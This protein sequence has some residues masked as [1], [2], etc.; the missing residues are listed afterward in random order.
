VAKDQVVYDCE[1]YSN[2]FMLAFKHVATGKTKVFEIYHDPDTGETLDT[3]DCDEVKKVF[4]T[5]EVV[6]FN[7]IKFDDPLIAMALAGRTTAEIKR[8]ADMII[9]EG[10][11]V[12]D[13]EKA[14]NFKTLKPKRE[15]DLIEVKVGDCSLKTLGGRMHSKRMQDLP[16]DPEE[17]ITR[18]QLDELRSYC[19]NDLDT[20]IDLLKALDGPLK[21]RRDMIQTYPEASQYRS[22]M[23]LSEGQIAEA[24][25][26]FEAEKNLG[27][28]ISK[29]KLTSNFSFGY[30]PASWL[31][32][33]TPLLQ[34]V[35]DVVKNATF[36]VDDK[37][38]IVI[39]KEILDLNIKIGDMTYTLAVGGLHSTESHRSLYSDDEFITLDADCGAMYPTLMVSCSIEPQSYQGQF[40]DVFSSILKQRTQAKKD[41]NKL[42]ADKLKLLCNSSYGRTGSK[43]STFYD[44]E[45]MLRVTLTGQLTLLQLIEMFELCG[46]PVISANTDGVTCRF[47]RSKIGLYDNII[48]K[49]EKLTGFE[50]EVVE[51]KSIHNASVNSY[52]A[53]KPD[54]SIKQKGPYSEPGLQ[55]NPNGYVCSIAVAEFLSKGTPIEDTIRNHTDFRN[56]VVVRNVTGG[57]V[58]GDTYLGKAVRWYYA[59]GETGI[60]QYKKNQNKV[61]LSL[62]AKPCM[63][64]PDEFPPDVDH[65]KYLKMT[66]KI[67]VD[68]GVLPQ[69][70]KLPR[71]NSK[72]FKQLLAEG[73][74]EENEEGKYEWV[75]VDQ[76]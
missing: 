24:I 74:I 10:K 6:G 29:P 52:F 46:I 41:K 20:T 7:T 25:I 19:V 71:K 35:F 4:D 11:W 56:F 59:K 36:E 44:A 38:K 70:S 21:M 53:V 16:I 1:V 34:N 12:S 72:E 55:K 32:F 61:P 57:A 47:H 39:P 27:R 23:S 37:S 26:K 8:A 22:F 63:N 68:I 65:D 69:P 48:K 43:Y 31:R 66:K 15:I 13:I 54:G 33:Q 42:L 45:G 30:E 50:M 2:L 18:E 64:L 58:K 40:L 73:K 75:D 14:F 9:V 5:F 67:L 17:T 62:G 60:I 28:R 3:F 76:T 49:F 51:Y